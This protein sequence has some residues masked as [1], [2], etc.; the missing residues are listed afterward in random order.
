[1]AD[2]FGRVDV[3]AGFD[4]LLL[5]GFHRGGGRECAAG[6]VVDQL[7]VDVLQTSKD[8][9]TRAR[10]RPRN[11]RANAAVPLFAQANLLT[12]LYILTPIDFRP[13]GRHESLLYLLL[14]PYFLAPPLAPAFPLLPALR[15][16]SSPR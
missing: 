1:L 3:A 16:I 9:Q 15:R 8:I 10:S 14:S 2:R 13:I 7:D 11:L 4:R 6:V 12:H 5:I